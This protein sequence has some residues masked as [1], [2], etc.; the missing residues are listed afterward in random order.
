MKKSLKELSIRCHHAEKLELDELKKSGYQL[1]KLLP[2]HGITKDG[3]LEEFQCL[4]GKF[5]KSLNFSGDPLTL[6][7]SLRNEWKKQ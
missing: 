5:K 1:E 3:L 2:H 4:A 6:Q 7:K